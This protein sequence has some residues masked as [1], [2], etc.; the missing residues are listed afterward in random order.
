MR[1]A[2][3]ALLGDLG[4]TRVPDVRHSLVWIGDCREGGSARVISSEH[5]QRATSRRCGGGTDIWCV[6][7]SPARTSCIRPSSRGA[8]RTD[9]GR[10]RSRRSSSARGGCCCKGDSSRSCAGAMGMRRMRLHT[11]V[12]ARTHMSESLC[13]ADNLTGPPPRGISVRSCDTRR[14]A[15]TTRP[16][17]RDHSATTAVHSDGR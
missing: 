12:H 1:L 5:R 8:P 15:E 3:C 16:G 10:L 2:E 9:A 6:C 4:G 17:H 7:P 14:P 13:P 11:T